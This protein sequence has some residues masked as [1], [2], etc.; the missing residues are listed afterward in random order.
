MGSSTYGFGA[1][2]QRRSSCSR[3]SSRFCSVWR[4]RPLEVRGLAAIAA[5]GV[6]EVYDLNFCIM[7]KNFSEG[8]GLVFVEPCLAEI[9]DVGV[10]LILI[11]LDLLNQEPWDLP[12]LI[13]V[14][15][16]CF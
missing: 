7:M 8:C 11:V 9:C 1:G 6:V 16:E 13:L 15:A 3:S 12:D 5:V 4:L 10:R 2:F 14:E